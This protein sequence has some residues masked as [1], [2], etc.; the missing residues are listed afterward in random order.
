M[1][2]TSGPAPKAIVAVGH[3]D[4]TTDT[5]D[6]LAQELPA[7][8]IPLEESEGTVRAHA[9]LPEVFARALRASGLRVTVAIPATG[10]LPAPLPEQ[11]RQAAERLLELAEH[12]R[13]LP[14]D[15]ADRHTCISADEQLIRTCSRLLAVWDGSPTDGRDA[16]AHLVAYAR[17]NGVEVD[18]VWPSGA[19]RR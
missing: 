14:Y 2:G 13:L 9:G 18:V 17:A 8:L 11:D 3:G 7:R 12:V 10:E 6:L 16:T 19:A 1:T 15:P 5:L 4:L